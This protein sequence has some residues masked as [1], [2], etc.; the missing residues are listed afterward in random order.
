MQIPRNSRRTEDVSQLD[1]GTFIGG[2]FSF[3]DW[4]FATSGPTFVYE[5][6]PHWHLI[7]CFEC[8][9]FRSGVVFCLVDVVA[10]DAKE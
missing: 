7:L 5:G 6:V 8:C 2:C 3:S 10:L 4:A 1:R 9:G